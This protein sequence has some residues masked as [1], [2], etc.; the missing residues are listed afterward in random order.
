MHATS[1][2][3]PRS[4]TPPGFRHL[5]VAISY[6]VSSFEGRKKMILSTTSLLE[7]EEPISWD[8]V[9]CRGVC[10]PP[11]WDSVPLHPHQVRKEVSQ[12][13]YNAFIN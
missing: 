4:V 6:Q 11:A 2:S 10:V 9:H 13:C 12:L 3:S 7:W 5:S 1:A 8:S